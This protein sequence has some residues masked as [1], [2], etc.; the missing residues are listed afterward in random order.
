MIHTEYRFTRYRPEC[1]RRDHGFPGG[2]LQ[3]TLC[4]YERT[5]C[6]YEPTLCEYEPTLCEYGPARC[7]DE[8]TL[9]EH[10][11]RYCAF[12]S[13]SRELGRSRSQLQCTKGPDWR[14]AWGRPD[15]QPRVRLTPSA[16]PPTSVQAR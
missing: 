1:T 9:P 5:L 4:E 16:E 8:P 14:T 3:R 10:A 12:P 2:A 11:R 7:E 6:E 13:T 15:T